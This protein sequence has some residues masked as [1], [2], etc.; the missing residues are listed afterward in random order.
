MI[1]EKL[2]RLNSVLSCLK[3]DIG[4]GEKKERDATMRVMDRM[5]RSPV[6]VKLPLGAGQ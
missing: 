6:S 2:A 3:G 5:R 1:E 4:S